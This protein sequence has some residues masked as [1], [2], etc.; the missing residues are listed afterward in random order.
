MKWN[1]RVFPATF[2]FL[3]V[4]LCGSYEVVVWFDAKQFPEIAKGERRVCFQT[5]VGVVVG[6]RE[7]ASLAGPEQKGVSQT[8]R[9][10]SVTNKTQQRQQQQRPQ[11]F[12]F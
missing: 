6:R 4:C 11:Q 12:A 9:K 1:S 3:F 7:T 5:E 10:N 8:K 2:F